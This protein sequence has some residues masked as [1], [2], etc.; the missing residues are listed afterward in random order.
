MRN[1][2]ANVGDAVTMARDAV[3][4]L[5]EQASAQYRA[6]MAQFGQNPVPLDIN[7][8]RQRMAAIKP[9]SYDAWVD[10]THRPADHIA[11][12][13]MNNA[14]EGYAG[15]AM[16]NPALLEPLAMDQFKQDLYDIGSKTGG[17]FDKDA[18]R[19]ARTAYNGVK[20]EL[21]RHDPVYATTMKNYE[22]A[23]KEA[24]QLDET[25]GLAAARGKEPN[26][27]RATRRL[28]SIM[29]NNAYT[30]YGQRA[31]QGER[32]AELDPTGTL[33][34]SLAGQTASAIPPRGL[35]GITGVGAG[36]AGYATNPVSLL[37]APLFSPRGMGELTYGLGR[38]AGTGAR[39]VD[40]AAPYADKL[41]DL[42]SKY[43][44]E[45]LAAT[46][47]GSLTGEGIEAQQQP[48][49]DQAP[50]SLDLPTITEQLRQRYALGGP[51]HLDMLHRLAARYG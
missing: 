40:A 42:Y 46:Q 3:G 13:K 43:A 35:Q 44:P 7:V 9:K 48:E 39:V 17:A 5:R 18:A 24:Q 12:E 26:I 10:K 33:L 27:D 11:W 4:N 37:A 28:Q 47:L 6:Q 49:E 22:K 51:V 34:A 14:V 19:I 29:R 38:A 23:A 15:E 1:P 25:F 30:N 36:I 31:G 20:D 32:L 45:T 21:I 41:Y 2:E 50:P 8:V 16:Q